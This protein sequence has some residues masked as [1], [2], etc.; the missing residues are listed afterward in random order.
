MFK[1]ALLVT[2]GFILSAVLGFIS[3]I[4]FASTFGAS[5]EMDV[6]FKILSVPA[7][8]TGIIPIIFASVLIPTFAKFKT[9]KSELSSFINSIWIFILVFGIFF[10][11]IGF[12]L[13]Y[14]NIDLFTP[15]KKIS[16][17]LGIHLALMIWLGSGFAIMSGYLSAILNYKK[18]FFKVSWTALLHGILIIS[19]VL[20]LHEYL[21]VR[22]I[23]LG[24]CIALIL[25]FIILLKASNI[26]FNFSSF[27]IKQIPYKKLLLK[28]SFLV[29]LSLLPFTILIPI[30]YFWASKLEVGSVSYL[31]YS[32]SFAGF[33]SVAVSMGISVVS[34]P[35]LADKFANEKGESS[36][37]QFEQTLRYTMMIT[38]F[39]AGAFVALRLQILTL[40]YGRGIFDTESVRNLSSVVP[41]YLLAAVFSSGLNLL[42]TLFYSRGEYKNIAKLGLIIPIIFFIFAGILKEKFSFVGIGM[43]NALTFAILFFAT[44]HLAKNK[45]MNFLT[46]D[47]L[48]FIF[49]NIIAVIFASL[50]IASILPLISNLIPQ[51][52]VNGTYQSVLIIATSLFCFLF[53][54]LFF[55]R[56]VLRLKEL[57]D[58]K[59]ILANKLKLLNK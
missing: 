45:E 10:A 34:L 48:F 8:V 49:K 51:L 40:F 21:G 57:N 17:N 9:N 13:V 4:V 2:I 54:Y 44:I 33:L 42:R 15:E 6:Y 56:F 43:A 14:I 50:T 20:L 18:Q 5:A 28:E 19:F 55:C 24:F 12:S 41:W 11:L 39:A 53:V 16:S 30:A 1:N 37:Y 35:D 46:S 52:I 38:I 58:L 7:I 47:F 27:N 25:Q 22:S 59:V 32:Q 26:S 31:G 29:T 3:Q 23:S 36:L